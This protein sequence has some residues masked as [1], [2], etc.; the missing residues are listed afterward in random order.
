MGGAGPQ[1]QDAPFAAF[2][3]GRHEAF[4]VGQG[5]AADPVVGHGGGPG[6]AHRQEVAEA[7]VVLEPQVGVAAGAALAGLLLGQPAVLVVELVAK[8]IEQRVDAVVD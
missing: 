5:L 6:P 3:G 4:L 7:A 1:L 8:A 2:E